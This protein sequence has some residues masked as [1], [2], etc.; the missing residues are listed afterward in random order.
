MSF[1]R[2]QAPFEVESQYPIVRELGGGNHP[3]LELVL[4]HRPKRVK[5]PEAT[6]IL[7]GPERDERD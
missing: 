4:H 3:G 1:H 7:C 5:D 6:V 2:L